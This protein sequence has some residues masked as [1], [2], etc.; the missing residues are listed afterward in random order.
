MIPYLHFGGYRLVEILQK[1]NS[2][3]LGGFRYEIKEK[4]NVSGDV[5]G[6][7]AC[8]FLFCWLRERK[9]WW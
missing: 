9:W 8:D 2:E 1:K 6:N 5:A 4:C 3:L 7:D